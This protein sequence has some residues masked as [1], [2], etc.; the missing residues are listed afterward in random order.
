MSYIRVRYFIIYFIPLYIVYCTAVFASANKS[1]DGAVY[2]WLAHRMMAL[3][4]TTRS[5]LSECFQTLLLRQLLWRWHWL[6]SL[7]HR[8]SKRGAGAKRMVGIADA[9]RKARLRLVMTRHWRR[10]PSARS[11][12]SRRSASPRRRPPR[13]RW[14]RKSQGCRPRDLPLDQRLRAAASPS[15]VHSHAASVCK[16]RCRKPPTQCLQD[17]E[18][19]SHAQHERRKRAVHS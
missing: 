4:W 14:Q 7:L 12:A 16:G 17:P 8:Q 18:T 3:M 10:Q 5:M 2:S 1:V 13:T 15:P 9:T 6:T 19:R 11:S